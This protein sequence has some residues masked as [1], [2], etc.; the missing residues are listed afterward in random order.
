MKRF[1]GVLLYKKRYVESHTRWDGS[2]VKGHFRYVQMLMEDKDIWGVLSGNMK[3]IIAR[4]HHGVTDELPEKYVK[5]NERAIAC[6]LEYLEELRGKGWET[7]DW[8]GELGVKADVIHQCIHCERW[9][10]GWNV[11]M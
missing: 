11:Y 1:E 6:R 3:N 5:M 8:C 2:F 4:V 9:Q 10:K 7:C